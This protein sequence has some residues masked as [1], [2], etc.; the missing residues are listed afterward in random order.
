MNADHTDIRKKKKKKK[1]ALA[2]AA[3]AAATAV[4]ST[5]PRYYQRIFS[6]PKLLCT[7]AKIQNSA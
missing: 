5:H 4:A 6:K 3:V 2:L 1:Q 7:V